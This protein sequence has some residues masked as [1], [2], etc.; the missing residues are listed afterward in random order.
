VNVAVLR[1]G[2]VEVRGAPARVA[3]LLDTRT[4]IET[5]EHVVL[6]YHL[7]GPIRRGLAWGIDTLIRGAVLF[8]VGMVASIGSAGDKG[9]GGFKTG[10]MLVLAFLLEWVYFVV[11]DVI[12]SGRSPGKKA[13]Q[14]RVVSAQGLPV[15]LGDSLLRNL[16]RT[17]DFLPFGY[18]LGAAT[19]MLDGRFRRLGDLVANTLVI[20]EPRVAYKAPP[21]LS[22]PPSKAEQDWLPPHV[23]LSASEREAI[24]LFMLRVAELPPARAD[25]LADILALPLAKRLRLKYS[26]PAR[27]LGLVYHCHIQAAA[28]VAGKVKR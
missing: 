9:L 15:S 8:A 23:E 2:R 17:A 4:D 28:K 21:Q 7:A 3:E 14:L 25:E 12:M 11:C 5:P 27:F 1:S 19:M 26:H 24:E 6:S 16:L 22:P 18:V 10:L 13:L 20:Y